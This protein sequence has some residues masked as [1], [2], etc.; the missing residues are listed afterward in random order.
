MKATVI[1]TGARVI[2]LETKISTE[3]GMEMCLIAP[4]G[5]IYAARNIGTGFVAASKLVLA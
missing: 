5:S 2:I 4:A 1:R 3:T